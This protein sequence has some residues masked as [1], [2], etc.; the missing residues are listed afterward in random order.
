MMREDV[1][2]HVLRR[3]ISF[4][5]RVDPLKGDSFENNWANNS[6]DTMQLQDKAG[7]VLYGAMVQTVANYCF[8]RM[9][10]GSGVA[11][12]ESVAPGAFVV[13]CFVPARAFHGRIHAITRTWDMDGEWIDREAMQ[14]STEGY[15]TG[16]W[17]IHDRW[18]EKLGRDTN[19]AWSAGCFV[20]S[21]E[22]LRRMNEVLDRWGVSC[23]QEMAGI[24]EELE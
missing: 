17:L 6:C 1:R 13:R 23:G 11:H 21:S 4:H 8:G 15:Q 20:L 16:R 24:L 5:Y 18:S 14:I 2:M 12:G 3:R 7:R 22:D 10:P 9:P 19:Y